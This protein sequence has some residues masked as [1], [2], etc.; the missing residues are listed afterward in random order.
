LNNLQYMS[1]CQNI[2]YQTN[3]YLF[4]ELIIFDNLLFS[5]FF[6]HS[7]FELGT[8]EQFILSEL[9]SKHVQS[10]ANKYFV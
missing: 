10:Q 1:Y 8:L 2:H 9:M 6:K 4:E 3:K 5:V 7:V